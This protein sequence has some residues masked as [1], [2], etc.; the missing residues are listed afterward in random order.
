MVPPQTVRHPY[1]S[2]NEVPT[3]FLHRCNIARAVPSLVLAF[4]HRFGVYCQ[5]SPQSRTR[6]GPSH[7]KGALPGAAS[8]YAL[9]NWAE[10]LRERVP[11]WPVR[12]PGFS[13]SWKAW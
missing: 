12:S 6:N 10:E 2:L 8:L 5:G 3:G 1:T 9:Q 4:S 11:N 7:P 13:S